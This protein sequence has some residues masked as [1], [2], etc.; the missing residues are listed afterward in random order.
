MRNYTFNFEVET[1][2]NQFMGAMDDIIVK[3]YNKERE[4]QSQIKARFVYA[5]KQRVLA[6]LLDK[7]QNLQLPVVAVYLGGLTRD[8]SRVFNK[9]AGSHREPIDSSV[10]R[11]IL[12]PTPI[13]LNINLTILTRYQKD[14][15]QIITNFVPYFDPY[16]VISWR[17]PAVPEQEIRSVVNWSGNIGLTYPTDI[18]STVVARV[19]ADTQFTIKG[20]MFKAEPKPDANIFNI[21]STFNSLMDISLEKNEYTTDRISV[22]GVPQP[23]VIVS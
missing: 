15:D 19:Q 14:M 13:D 2:I 5:P 22:S 9:L 16:I 11:K 23:A 10:Y 21:F 17:T 8:S 12:Q 7:A 18:N 6:D 1:M 20:W 3:R 4:P